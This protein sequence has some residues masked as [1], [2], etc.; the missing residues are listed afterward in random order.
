VIDIRNN[1]Y[2]IGTEVGIVKNWCSREELQLV[3]NNGLE[4]SKVQKDKF[5]SICEAVANINQNQIA[6]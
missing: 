2:Q 1:V 3:S 5:V 6:F 4:D